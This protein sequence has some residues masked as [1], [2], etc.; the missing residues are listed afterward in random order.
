MPPYMS[1]SSEIFN[2]Y[3]TKNNISSSNISDSIVVSITILKYS[4]E[5]T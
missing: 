5:N 4:T 3:S 2:I 1:S